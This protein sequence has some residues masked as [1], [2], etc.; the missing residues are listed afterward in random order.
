M[1][2]VV[3]ASSSEESLSRRTVAKD[4][5]GGRTNAGDGRLKVRRA[6]IF[7]HFDESPPMSLLGMPLEHLERSCDRSGDFGIA[8]CA[9]GSSEPRD[10]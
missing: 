5:K 4:M 9:R 1:F 2:F 3:F 6:D 10:A 8:Y 7:I